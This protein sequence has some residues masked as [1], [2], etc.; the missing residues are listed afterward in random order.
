VTEA[1]CANYD[2]TVLDKFY[3]DIEA[4]NKSAQWHGYTGDLIK[5]LSTPWATDAEME[6]FYALEKGRRTM[7]DRLFVHVLN[8][9]TG[10][11]S[12][13]CDPPALA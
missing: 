1:R 2:G 13:R 6:R 3:G 11:T 12:R 8:I 10:P 9:R 7:I 5:G 4:T